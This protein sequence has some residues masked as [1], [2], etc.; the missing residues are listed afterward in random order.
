MSSGPGDAGDREVAGQLDRTGS[1]SDGNLNRFQTDQV[2][3]ESRFHFA[4]KIVAVHGGGKDAPC[5][6]DIQPVVKQAD[7]QG[8]SSSHGTIYG[9][10]VTRSIGGDSVVINDPKV[11]DV[12]T[13]SVLDRDHSSSQ[14]NDWAEANPGSKRR[15][16]L[17][18]AV[19]HGTLPRKADKPKQW[20]WFK[21]DG[22]EM[23]DRNG[24]TLIGGKDGWKLNGVVVT[25][26]GEVKAPGNVTAGEGTG[27]KVT[28]Q[29]HVHGTTPKPTSGS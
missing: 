6:V 3:G 29:Q 26:K 14:V 2:I 27:N 8:K 12:A 15:N 21:D 18:D 13:F 5:I 20:I 23:A 4:A 19:Y 24:N 25:Q 1:N 9:I 10:P 17:S 16:S 22:V 7:G 28:L 11:G